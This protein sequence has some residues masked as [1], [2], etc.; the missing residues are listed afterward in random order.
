MLNLEMGA[1]EPYIFTLNLKNGAP[2]LYIFT[3]NL[4][5]GAPELYFFMLNLEMG[6]PDR[7]INFYVK[8]EKWGPWV[9]HFY[10]ELGNGGP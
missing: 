5:M 3:L 4:E 8:F 6:A 2:E 7:A 9:I 1:P 10:T